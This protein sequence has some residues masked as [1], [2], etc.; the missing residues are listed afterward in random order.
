MGWLQLDVNGKRISALCQ[1]C[2]RYLLYSTTPVRRLNNR[3]PSKHVCTTVFDFVVTYDG[4]ATE[5]IKP[6]TINHDSIHPPISFV[7]TLAH[8][9]LLGNFDS[10]I[11]LGL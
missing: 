8:I 6:F 3:S 4:A 7:A 10:V 5:S 11:Q 1:V 9:E 2:G